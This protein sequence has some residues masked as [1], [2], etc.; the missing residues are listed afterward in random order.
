MVAAPQAAGPAAPLGA[1]QQ[2]QGTRRG[3]GTSPAASSSW[4]GGQGGLLDQACVVARCTEHWGPCGALWGPAADGTRDPGTIVTCVVLVGE[5]WRGV[6]RGL[7][8]LCK[9]VGDNSV[10]AWH[11]QRARGPASRDLALSVLIPASAF[12][13]STASRVA[14]TPG[15]A[16]RKLQLQPR[17]RAE[18]R[19]RSG[20][21]PRSCPAP[22]HAASATV[23]IQVHAS[24]C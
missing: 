1:F 15:V 6:R 17:G 20:H 22:R 12:A 9:S 24:E 7:E 10:S 11:P 21:R 2:S 23:M 18:A 16:V 13:D 4:C 8:E 5:A 14:Y 3:S 19:G